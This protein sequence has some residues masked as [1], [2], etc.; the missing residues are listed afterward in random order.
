MKRVVVGG[1]LGLGAYMGY[2]WYLQ[3]K[4]FPDGV[5]LGNLLGGN[6]ILIAGAVAAGAGVAW[7][8][9]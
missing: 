9:S 1:L 8:T 2:R 3:R 7:G 4:Y 5:P 6:P